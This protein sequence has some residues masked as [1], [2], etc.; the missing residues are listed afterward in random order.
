MV[1][2]RSFAVIAQ[3]VQWVRCH[4]GLSFYERAPRML[5]S[6]FLFLF[7][8]LMLRSFVSVA[9]FSPGRIFLHVFPGRW[10]DLCVVVA[11][12]VVTLV[13]HSIFSWSFICPSFPGRFVVDSSCRF[14]PCWQFVL[15]PVD[16]VH[17]LM[18]GLKRFFH[19]TKIAPVLFDS[20]LRKLFACL[21]ASLSICHV[22]VRSV[23]PFKAHVL[24]Q[25][26]WSLCFAAFS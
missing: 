22:Q 12:H 23:F 16:T 10:L 11:R 8:L 9:P 7:R 20:V 26:S 14:A 5:G 13:S 19:C 25:V 18:S 15:Q 1:A 3:F 2:S 21:V 4:P 24:H 17:F 6:S